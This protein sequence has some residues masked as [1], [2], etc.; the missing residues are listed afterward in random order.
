MYTLSVQLCLKMTKS[1]AVEDPSFEA[2]VNSTVREKEKKKLFHRNKEKLFSILLK[3][4]VI[5][6]PSLYQMSINDSI[7]AHAYEMAGRNELENSRL[8]LK[9]F[10]KLEANPDPNVDKILKLLLNL[11]DTGVD[12]TKSRLVKIGDGIDEYKNKENVKDFP[13]GIGCSLKP[14]RVY[15]DYPKELFNFDIDSLPKCGLNIYSKT[16]FMFND[17]LKDLDLFNLEPKLGIDTD[18][19]SLYSCKS[20]ESDKTIDQDEGY[21]TPEP[22]EDPTEIWDKIWEVE[23]PRRRTWESLGAKIVAKELP[24]LSEVGHDAV[25]QA[26]TTITQNLCLVDPTLKIPPLVIIPVS[27]LTGDIGY[28]L[29]GIPSTTFSFSPLTETFQLVPGTCLPGVS[30]ECL[31]SL[32]DQYLKAG[33]IV[34]GLEN[35][36]AQNSYMGNIFE[37]IKNGIR[38]FLRVYTNAVV[39]L[40]LK[41]NSNLS[42]LGQVLRPL[43]G[44]ISFLGSVCNLDTSHNQEFSVPCGVSLLSKLLDVSVQ[45]SNKVVHLLLVAL[46]TAAASPYFKFLESWLFSGEVDGHPGEFGLEIE[47]RYINAK[48]SSYWD[49]AYNLIPIEGSSFLKDIQQKVHLTGMS[50]ALLRLVC[51]DHYLAGMFRHIQPSIKLAIAASD[52]VQLKESCKKYE[53]EIEII[54][55]QLTDNLAAKKAK[56][57]AARVEHVQAINQKNKDIE[58]RNR[59]MEQKKREEKVKKQAEQYEDIQNQIRQTKARKLKEKEEKEEE[60]KKIERQAQKMEEESQRGSC[61]G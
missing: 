12:E 9:N 27:R 23:V 22:R 20:E 40:S 11:K 1:V 49:K 56:E 37:G 36:C 21:I 55:R 31:A 42:E 28:L 15:K 53:Q 43:A 3:K 16:S 45:V 14:N 50:L 6:A 17:D 59:E 41:F 48:D 10:A 44:Q 13:Y 26:W 5:K 39:T 25:H 60:E 29:A 7:A 33:N 38:S 35:F 8:L 19:T 58:K 2:F 51:P 32:C 34:R 46:L 18:T 54:S 47:P 24:Y 57:E 61:K 4:R 52:Q 30:P